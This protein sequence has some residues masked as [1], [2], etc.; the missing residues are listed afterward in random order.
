MQIAAIDLYEVRLALRDEFATSSHRKD[1]I[2]HIIVRLQDRS[3]GVGFGE[4]ACETAPFFGAETVQTCWHVLTTFLG[5]ALLALEWQ[6][7][8]QAWQA[9]TRYRGNHVAKAGLDMAAWDL[10]ARSQGVSLSRVLGGTRDRIEAGISLGIAPTPAQA[11]DRV[12]RAAEQGYRRI[13]L[14]IRPGMAEDIVRQAR[15]LLDGDQPAIAV[16]ANGSYDGSDQDEL[17]SLDGYGL[18]LIEQP[19][20][21]DEW[22]AHRDLATALVTPV[23]LDESITSMGS[24]KLALALGACK[25][26]NIKVSR[27]GGLT[28][29]VE[30]HNMCRD[31]GIAV[32]CGAMHEFGI[33]RA[34]NV[35][36]ASLPGFVMP[37]DISG[38]AERYAGY[39][40]G[41]A[42]R[43][44]GGYIPVPVGPGIGHHVDEERIGGLAR[45]HIRLTERQALPRPCASGQRP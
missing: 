30:L 12:A 3:G 37:G 29:A 26:I 15:R 10:Y 43:A 16:D 9:L 31:R 8:A 1:A 45:R 18:A 24:A 7:P 25:I 28:P 27:L 17:R 4:C 21:P 41:P 19:F 22:Q 40:A 5:P 39:T 11:L 38:S 34:A 36:L 14:K 6:H 13:K 42:I 2:T 44:E 33:G 35:A 20:G 32:W 23:C